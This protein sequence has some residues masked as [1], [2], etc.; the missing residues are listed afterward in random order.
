[1]PKMILGRAMSAALPI[2]V[3]QL[4]QVLTEYA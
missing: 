1:L 3:I 2:P 4:L